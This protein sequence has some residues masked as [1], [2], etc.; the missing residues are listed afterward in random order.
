MR[1]SAIRRTGTLTSMTTTD[2]TIYDVKLP[3]VP[4]TDKYL[5]IY[6]EPN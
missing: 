4:Y 6:V 5:N 1:D 3:N 2:Q